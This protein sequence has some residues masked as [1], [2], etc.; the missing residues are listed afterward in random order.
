MKSLISKQVERFLREQ[1]N[2]KRWLAVFLCLAVV[3]TIGTTAALK[4]K[5]IA[6]TSDDPATEEMHMDEPKEIPEG[7]RLHVHTDACYEEQEVKALVCGYGHVH[8]ESCYA[9]EGGETEKPEETAQGQQ[10]PEGT[11]PEQKPDS[12]SEASSPETKPAPE[13]ETKEERTLVCDEEEGHTHGDGCYETKTV[14]EV[15]GTDEEGNDIIE[16][17]EEKELNCDKEEGHTHSDSCY[18]VKTV[19]VEAAPVAET[20]EAAPVVETEEAASVAET[21]EAVPVAE[22]KEALV[23]EATEATTE[24]TPDTPAT[25]AEGNTVQPETPA[26]DETPAP[27][28]EKDAVENDGRRLICGKELGEGAE[29][30]GHTHTEECYEIRTE[31]VLVCGKE[32]GELEEIPYTDG[33][34]TY[35]GEDY[36]VTISYTAEAKIPENAELRVEEL[37]KDSD[38]YKD[39]YERMIEALPEDQRE[40]EVTFVRLFDITILSDGDEMEPEATVEVKISYDDLVATEEENGLT[41]HFPNEGGVEI[42]DTEVKDGNEFEFSQ[43]SFSVVLN[44]LTIVRGPVYEKVEITSL[45]D[46]IPDEPYLIVCEN[47]NTGGA[48][49]NSNSYAWEGG[50]DDASFTVKDTIVESDIK[51]SRGIAALEWIFEKTTRNNRFYIKSGVESGGK[52]YYLSIGNGLSGGRGRG[53][54]TSESTMAFTISVDGGKILISAQK[55]NT[56]YYVKYRTNNGYYSDCFWADSNNGTKL[57]LYKKVQD[58]F[59]T[60]YTVNYWKNENS[61][62][63]FQNDVKDKGTFLGKMELPVE[64]VDGKLYITIPLTGSIEDNNGESNG[65]GKLE[66]YVTGD[67]TYKFYGWSQVSSANYKWGKSEQIY[68]GE[69]IVIDENI[70]LLA[71]PVDG[72]IRLDVTNQVKQNIDLYAIWAAPSQAEEN[73]VKYY[74]GNRTEP[75]GKLPGVYFFVSVNGEVKQEPGSF[76]AGKYTDAITAKDDQGNEVLNPL[77]YWMHIYGN[78]NDKA[79]SANLRYRPTDE[80]IWKAVKAKGTIN[81]NGKNVDFGEI[82]SKEEFTSKYYVVWYVCKDQGNWWHIDGALMEKENKWNLDY[83][84]NGADDPETVISLK[85]YDYKKDATVMNSSKDGVQSEDKL[86]RKGY[87]FLGWE[88]WTTGENGEKKEITDFNCY[89]EIT[90]D[91]EG[92]VYKGPGKVEGLKADQDE[93]GVWTVTLH[94]KWEKIV[95]DYTIEKG[96]ADDDN[97]A[98]KPFVKSVT[99]NIQ[100]YTTTV[101]GEGNEIQGV[102]G[103]PKAPEIVKDEMVLSSSNE[104]SNTISLDETDDSGNPYTYTI[105]E[106]NIGGENNEEIKGLLDSYN[107]GLEKDKFDPE[108]YV[109]DYEKTTKIYTVQNVLD[110]NKTVK[111]TV[112]KTDKTGKKKLEGAVFKLTKTGDTNGDIEIKDDYIS[113]KNGIAIENVVLTAGTYE[114]QEISAPSGYVLDSNPISFTVKNDGTPAAPNMVIQLTS[115]GSTTSGWKFDF[116]NESKTGIFTMQDE[117]AKMAIK[118]KKV[119][120]QNV[121]GTEDNPEGLEGAEFIVSRTVEG[122]TT[123]FKPSNSENPWV[124]SIDEADKFTTADGKNGTTLGVTNISDLPV[125][126][127]E[128]REVKAPKGYNLQGKPVKFEIAVKENENSLELVSW[129]SENAIS[130]EL[131]D[132]FKDKDTTI[133]VLNTAG[134]I[135]PETGGPGTTV[136]TFGGLAMIIAVGLMY[137][138]NM[139]RKRGKGGMM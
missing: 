62:T 17:H 73:G 37:E 123:Y 72:E 131:W 43:D 82:E 105:A 134:I 61:V 102:N 35:E 91:R 20:E 40:A 79:V 98:I 114:L 124:N 132:K 59:P 92:N 63:S 129:Q 44:A 111:I 60:T 120:D 76:D 55:D 116:N 66:D 71:N 32:E 13:P 97:L 128:L 38:V 106:T 107:L 136:Y 135:L 26:A 121:S 8:D 99:L 96:W 34:L 30:E 84:G 50:L 25:D 68:R 89:D 137:G 18:E 2:Y 86:I 33:T 130:N 90:V 118:V 10:K 103:E 19:E 70:T 77:Y 109:L 42:I 112:Q 85:Q 80:D 46:I 7:Y 24:T 49:G 22:T 56:S 31:K 125:G 53:L 15:V 94:A 93:G 45:D 74:G 81:V 104:W 41:V 9:A 5:G 122:V 88:T 36:K 133:T 126:K 1:K 12:S 57:T 52:P 21:K 101:D 6:V 28:A 65:I 95:H 64:E 139:R 78:G 119:S 115:A 14:E 11:A 75:T 39:Y 87:N 67:H 47:G 51:D 4:Y 27:K 127:Y 100:R 58:G 48:M 23:T 29:E 3:V 54:T 83:D 108:R 69:N 110:T 113:D 117:E 138:L 16:T